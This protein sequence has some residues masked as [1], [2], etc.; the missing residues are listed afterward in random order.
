MRVLKLVVLGV[1][2]VGAAKC[3]EGAFTAAQDTREVLSREKW[4]AHALV[5]HGRRVHTL[6]SAVT[7]AA[8]EDALRMALR[9]KRMVFEH[10]Y[11]MELKKQAAFNG[12]VVLSVSV[13]VDGRITDAHVEEGSRRDAAVGAC[14][15]AQLRQLKL[16]PVSEEADLLV[17][18]RLE[19]RKDT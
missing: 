6:A 3:F 2:L 1:L 7:P 8:P 13:T 16:P 10:C 18:I 15:A 14:I 17:P 11:E 12:F 19:A 9:R 4:K 5:V